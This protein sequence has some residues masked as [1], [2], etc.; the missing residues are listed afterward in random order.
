M[1]GLKYCFVKSGLF[2]TVAT[3]YAQGGKLKMK[4]MLML[5][6]I[7]AVMFFSYGF[8]YTAFDENGARYPDSLAF[9]CIVGETLLLALSIFAGLIARTVRKR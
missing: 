5:V 6:V 4:I 9:A 7:G 2:I 1:L 3:K 8:F